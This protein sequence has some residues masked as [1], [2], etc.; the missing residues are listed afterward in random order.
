[1]NAWIGLKA[2]YD[3]EML[4]YFR[5]PIAYFV[6][7]VFLLGTGYFFT[8]NIF[9]TGVGTMDQ[10]L[11]NMGILLITLS[12]VLTMRLFSAEY[13]GR[14]ME[15]LMTLPLRTWQVVLGKYLG[16]VS[17]LVLMTAASCINL[18]PLY[19]YGNPQ[20]LNILA[21]YIGF[22]LLGMACI[23]IGQLFRR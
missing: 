3:K 19:L 9:L 15:L 11:Q 16:A 10:T 20:T 5:S 17:M 1:M 13:N 8:Y 4:T 18:I 6:I 12:P 22:I 7:A 23:G 14:T 2:V 21:G